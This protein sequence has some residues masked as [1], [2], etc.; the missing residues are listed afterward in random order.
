MINVKGREMK[1]STKNK[2]GGKSHATIWKEVFIVRKERSFFGGC[3]V[4]C[5]FIYN[6]SLLL[7]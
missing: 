1:R 3:R 6:E 2:E 5:M 7:L 4:L